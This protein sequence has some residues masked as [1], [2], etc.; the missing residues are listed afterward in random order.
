M[1][2]KTVSPFPL[3]NIAH[4]RVQGCISTPYGGTKPLYRNIM[5]RHKNAHHES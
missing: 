5:D 2:Q 4:G 1:I 3:S